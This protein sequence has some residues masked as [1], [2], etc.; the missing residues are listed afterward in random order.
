[1]FHYYHLEQVWKQSEDWQVVPVV[2][3]TGCFAQK[4]G[5]ALPVC[6]PE[7]REPPFLYLVDSGW[8]LC[9]ELGC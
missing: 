3:N 7:T 8:G 6:Q 1:M 5:V 4:S 2:I 9:E